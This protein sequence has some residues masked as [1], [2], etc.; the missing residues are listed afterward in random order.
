[1][2][3]FWKKKKI[4]VT[5][6]D[7]F[8]GSHM[9]ALLLQQGAIVTG[10]TFYP[11]QQNALNLKKVGKNIRVVTGDLSNFKTCLKATKNQDIVLNFAGMDGGSAY[12]KEHSAQIFKTNSQITLSMLEA[13]RENGV[14]KF[15]LVSS[16]EVY[17][18][19]TPQ[20]IYERYGFMKGLDEKV[21]GYA[22][23]KRFSE[24]TAKLYNAQYGMEI[25]IVRPGNIYG[26]GDH[27]NKGRVVPTFISQSL[28]NKP[29]TLWNG[30]RQKKSFIHVKDF[31]RGVLELV[32]NYSIPDPVNLAGERYVSIGELAR[33]IITLSKSKSKIKYATGIGFSKERIV[34]L[35]KIKKVINF[36]EEIDLD[37][38]L[39][40]T[41]E[42][43]KK[44]KSLN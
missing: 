10:H 17:P 29:I 16:V 25:A 23:S 12:K 38:G 20:P 32:E 42:F 27:L 7:G 40:E 37:A 14:Q 15:L 26:P 36:K 24:I 1:M 30:G 21:D 5:G 11:K 2:S 41:I 22:W 39:A 44:V 8:I 3:N 31:T 34:S 6:S 18:E 13:S 28:Q 35:K 4:L 43:L 33:K 9:V 19:T